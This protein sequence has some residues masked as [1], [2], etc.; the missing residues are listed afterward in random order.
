M[1][2]CTTLLVGRPDSQIMALAG[3]WPHL[4]RRFF[5][6][7]GARRVSAADLGL[8]DRYLSSAERAL[9]RTMSPAD[10]QHSIDLGRRL[11]RDRHDNP[12]LIRAALL[13]DVGKASAP[14]STLHRVV[15]SVA[16]VTSP[17]FAAWLGRSAAGWRR[18]FFVAAH[19]AEL[20]AA[21][22]ERAGSAELVVRLI[23]EHGS[24]GA[25]VL[26]RVLYEYD[27]RM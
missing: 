2:R 4:A 21:A 18:P 10:Q 17:R 14:L 5:A 20:G 6:T 11:R 25:D 23:R 13:H 7:V 22:A 9:F 1:G 26:G 3:P 8:V 24:R 15:Y 12:D 27:R 16:S 19:H